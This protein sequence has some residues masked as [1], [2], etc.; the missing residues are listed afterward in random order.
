MQK[1]KLRRRLPHYYRAATAHSAIYRPQTIKTIKCYDNFKM[2]HL[3]RPIFTYHVN[4]HII[5]IVCMYVC[6]NMCALVNAR[7]FGCNEHTCNQFAGRVRVRPHNHINK[8]YA[9]AK[10]HTHTH[11]HKQ[12]RCIHWQ[13]EHPFPRK[14]R[15]SHA[16]A[17][18]TEM[19]V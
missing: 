9:K 5:H 2:P 16:N 3:Y 11:T 10:T 13:C 8:H 12:C 15:I 1:S 6:V 7:T 14:F 17:L 4:I 18:T 19:S